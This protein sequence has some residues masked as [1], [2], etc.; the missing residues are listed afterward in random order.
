MKFSVVIIAF[1]EARRIGMVLESIQGADEVIVVDSNSTDDTAKIAERFGAKVVQRAFDGFGQQKQFGVNSA[2]ND[3]IL[4][5]DA[6]EVPDKVFWDFIHQMDEN[7]TPCKAWY[8]KRHLVFMGRA[9]RFGKEAKDKQLRFFH[10]NYAQ[11]STPAVHEKVETQEKTGIIPGTVAHYSFESIDNYL[12]KFNRYT[13][14]AAEDLVKR[15]KSRSPFFNLLGIPFNFFKYYFIQLNILNGYAGLC[16]SVFSS[17]YPFVKY[18]KVFER[19]H[20]SNL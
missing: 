8:L 16:W 11:W 5:L 19:A 4:S 17:V 3:W 6:D 9:F 20:T 18:A 14:L 1:N 2:S 12:G 15:G 13:S 7:N 10:R